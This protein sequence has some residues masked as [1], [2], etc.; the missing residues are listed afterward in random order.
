MF[1]KVIGMFWNRSSVFEKCGGHHLTVIQNVKS[2]VRS[3]IN[4]HTGLEIAGKSDYLTQE[5]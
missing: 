3:H 5:M 2:L 4:V 1:L